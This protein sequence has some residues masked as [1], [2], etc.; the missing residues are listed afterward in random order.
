MHI[1]FI[2]GGYPTHDDPFIPFIKNTVAEM[3]K[4]GVR[5]T[6]I[7]P[8]SITRAII[9]KVPVRHE[10]WIDKIDENVSVEVLQPKFFSLS[11]RAQTINHNLFI[12]AAKKAYKNIK[13]VP[14]VLYGHFWHMGVVAS[15][16]DNSKPLFIACGE[17]K[18]SVQSEYKRTDIVQM[19]KQLSGVI[20][21]STKSYEESVSLGLQ[22]DNPYIIAPNGYDTSL[23]YKKAKLDCRK[24]LGWP[25]EGFVVAFVGA[26]IERK[27]AKRLSNVLT[28][29][30]ETLPVYSCFIGSGEEQPLCPNV[31]FAGKVAHEDIVTYLNASDIFVLPT[32]NEGCCNA[33]IEAMACGLPVVSSE[34]SFNNDILS[35]EYSIR[36]N[37]LDESEI[38]E[39]ILKIYCN[40]EVVA[41]MAEA[42]LCKSKELTIS[43]RICKM[44]DFMRKNL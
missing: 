19:Q 44:I 30:N 32:T 6:V 16:I 35:E 41:K 17:S 28:Q 33:I 18:I 42:S 38:K 26:F 34:G 2:V 9:H 11:G 29:I 20:Y 14:D 10:S 37:P 5:C 27:G 3:A 15:K 21:V 12:R 8:Q 23:F 24:A 7:A 22:K 1:C 43:S 36:V 40:E 13:E 25:D 39:A 4:Q 31:L